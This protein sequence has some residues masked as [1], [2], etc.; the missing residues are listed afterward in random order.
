MLHRCLRVPQPID[1]HSHQG[2]ALAQSAGAPGYPSFT[3]SKLV[4]TAKNIL[5]VH[6]HILTF[7]CTRTCMYVCT[8]YH[9]VVQ[10]ATGKIG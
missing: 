2:D 4:F 9:T 5:V 3:W 6:I 8:V 1:E 7:Q 10:S